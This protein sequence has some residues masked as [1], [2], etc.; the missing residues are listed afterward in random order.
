MFRIEFFCDDKRLAAALHALT[1]ISHGP[2]NVQ[3]VVNAMVNGRGDM[4]AISNGGAYERFTTELK[5][6]KGKTL[7]GGE[8]KAV[9]KAAGLN[10]TSLSYFAR[11]ARKAGLLKTFGATSKLQYKVL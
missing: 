6:H 9:A 3:P 7:N 10:P 11:N 4:T 8:M 1:G 5:K 2:P